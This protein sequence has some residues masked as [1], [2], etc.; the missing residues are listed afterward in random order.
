MA[1]KKRFLNK[2]KYMLTGSFKRNGYDWWWHSFTGF[3]KKT[4]ESRQ[5]FIE[6]F[7]INPG[8]SPDK[9]VFGQLK[10]EHPSYFMMKAGA[11][12][13]GGC[14]LHN[15]YPTK[16]VKIN[17]KKDFSFQAG[18]CFYSENHISGH[19]AVSAQTAKTHPEFMSDAG[20]MS[21]NL[22]VD[23]VTPF[24]VGYGTSWLFR[25]L[26]AFEM[27]WHAQGVKTLYS[28][29]VTLNG[30]EYAVI[31]D[32]CFGYA[33][34]NWG[35]DYTSPWI[36]LSSCNLTSNITRGKLHNTCFDIGGGK[37]RVFGIPLDRRVLVYL[38]YEGKKIEFN[39]SHFWV[40]SKVMFRFAEG[41]DLLH[42]TVSSENK[43]YLL[44]IDA[45]CRRSDTIFVNYESPK[46]R[47]DF[48][49]LW[50]GGNAYGN[51]K[52]FRKKGKMLEIIEDAQFMN[53]GC[54]YGEFKTDFS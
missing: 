27:Y 20:E 16:Q 28:G 32:T 53:C 48:D 5:F 42:W 4:G 3:N 13:Q 19:V 7:F 25:A 31:P 14:Q 11:W 44:D 29:T 24:N 37:P 35:K 50:N 45:Y 15:F 12:G 22:T 23:K 49:R 9:C 18:K 47:K 30:V 46:G 54:E 52:L 33:D 41:D 39:F 51:M 40:K 21:W 6:Y 8:R 36:W 10:G 34:K 17:R 38:N 26:K 43:E 2:N 1:D